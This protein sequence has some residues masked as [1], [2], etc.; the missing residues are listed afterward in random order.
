LQI[1]FNKIFHTFPCVRG[2]YGAGKRFKRFMNTISPRSY[3]FFVYE[4][5]KSNKGVHIHT[6]AGNLGDVNLLKMMDTWNKY[7]GYSR[8]VPYDANKGANFYIAKNIGSGKVEWD[9]ITNSE[10]VRIGDM[11]ILKSIINQ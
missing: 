6:L 7:D 3:Y 1:S 8:I 9:Y 10:P 5:N 2:I 11:G 4:N